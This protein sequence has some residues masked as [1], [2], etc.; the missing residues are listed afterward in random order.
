MENKYN[1]LDNPLITYTYSTNNKIDLNIT[2]TEEEIKIFDFIQST[3]EKYKLKV[4]VRV[5]GGWVRDKVLNLKSHDI[6]LVISGMKCIEFGLL[7]IKSK[8]KKL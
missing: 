5:A 1:L 4:E 8:C 2:L 7:L 3:I 6:D